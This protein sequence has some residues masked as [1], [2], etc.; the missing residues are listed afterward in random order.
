MR[1]NPLFVLSL[2]L[3]SL[4]VMAHDT[5]QD[6]EKDRVTMGNIYFAP[7]IYRDSGGTSTATHVGGGVEVYSKRHKIGFSLDGGFYLGGDLESMSISPAMAFFIP[8]EGRIDPFVKGGVTFLVLG[9]S[10]ATLGFLGAGLD[11][12]FQD[13]FGFRFEFRDQ[14]WLESFD[15]HFFEFRGAFVIRGK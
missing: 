9:E 10:T 14:F 15:T 3:F 4:P 7:T 8:G 5:E 11:W 12:W 13:R 1:K 2:I 6:T